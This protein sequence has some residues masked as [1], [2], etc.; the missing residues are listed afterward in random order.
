MW[1]PKN[2]LHPL[3]IDALLMGGFD[4]LTIEF[5][6]WLS[7]NASA[8]NNS[9]NPVK[10]AHTILA[11]AS[12]P[13]HK[14]HKMLHTFR[15]RKKESIRPMQVEDHT[16]ADTILKDLKWDIRT[17]IDIAALTAGDHYVDAPEGGVSDGTPLK[18]KVAAA[19][20]EEEGDE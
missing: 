18:V 5:L 12:D 15:N 16:E 13:D 8:L 2:H 19:N 7:Y 17:A 4:P 1:T 6:G 11:N 14:M 3:I 9:R 20:S 10:A